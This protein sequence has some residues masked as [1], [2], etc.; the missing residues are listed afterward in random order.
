MVARFVW[1]LGDLRTIGRDLL[2]AFSVLMLTVLAANMAIFYVQGTWLAIY[3]APPALL[4]RGFE[5][6]WWLDR[7]YN[8]TV[9]ASEYLREKINFVRD[10][11]GFADLF[12]FAPL[13][14]ELAYRGP[15]W[16]LRRHAKSWWWMALAVLLGAFFALA[17]TAGPLRVV[18][19]FGVALANAWL[20]RRTGKLWPA[21]A[22][23]GAYNMQ[24]TYW[25]ILGE[26]R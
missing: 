26:F 16:L 17:H 18:P 14:E 22:L 20:I 15:L 21:I 4:G 11:Y 12:V 25:N 3:L 8:G 7:F 19:V 1:R 10:Q 6:P 5:L 13:L 9:A 24:I 2:L 23:H